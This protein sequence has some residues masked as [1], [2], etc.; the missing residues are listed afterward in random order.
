[1][2]KILK[3]NH[4]S[5]IDYLQLGFSYYTRG[6]SG[7]LNTNKQRFAGISL[8]INLQEFFKEGSSARTFVKYFKV[9]YSFTG[10]F[11]ELNTNQTEIQTGNTVFNY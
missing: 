3:Y 2:R 9:P 1:V 11:R 6:Y 8:G 4:P 7:E 5:A 10:I